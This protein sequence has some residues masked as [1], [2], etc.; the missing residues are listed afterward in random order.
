MDEKIE[1]ELNKK[2][3]DKINEINTLN[4]SLEGTST[5]NNT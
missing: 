2:I 4:K 3:K 1:L 5:E